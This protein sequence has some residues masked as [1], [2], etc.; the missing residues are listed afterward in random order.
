MTISAQK[1][2]NV[3]WL[4]SQ[5]LP[6]KRGDRSYT[7]ICAGYRRIG[8]TCG[9]LVHWLLWRLGCKNPDL[10]NRPELPNSF[11][12]LDT[13]QKLR[14]RN[15]D[16][17]VAGGNISMIYEYS[18]TRQHP[19]AVM[20]EPGDIMIID[21][22]QYARDNKGTDKEYLKQHVFVFLGPTTLDGAPAW[23]TAEAG[24]AKA[25]DPDGT[26]EGSLGVRRLI[27]TQGRITLEQKGEPTGRSV[28]G[29]LP[30]DSVVFFEPPMPLK[31]Q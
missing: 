11:G 23:R 14:P 17:V 7:E 30:L 18:G 25:S 29:W 28:I 20:P 12:I 1:R 2:Q 16:G 9:H 3:E 22:Q 26:P 19:K 6:F 13:K 21:N 31:Y 10:V 4:M 15:L 24:K 5:Y 8:T 27:G